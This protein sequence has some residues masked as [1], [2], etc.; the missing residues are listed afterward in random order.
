MVMSSTD[1]ELSK[2]V[3]VLSDAPLHLSVEPEAGFEQLIER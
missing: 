3:L 1:R 2:T